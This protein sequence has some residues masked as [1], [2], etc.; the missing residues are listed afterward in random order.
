MSFFHHALLYILYLTDTVKLLFIMAVN[1]LH[2]S[3]I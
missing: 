2:L 3:V 1:I